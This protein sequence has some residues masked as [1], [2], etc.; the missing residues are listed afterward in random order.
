M[1]ENEETQS[2][3]ESETPTT[4]TPT[5]TE[6]PG[7]EP[8]VETP[9]TETKTEEAAPAPLTAE[10]IKLPEGMTAPEGM[11]TSFAEVMNNADLSAEDRASQLMNLHADAMKQASE[12]ISESWN[13]TREGWVD[14]IKADPE[15]GG[16]KLPDT[17]STIGKV[18]DEFG[19]EELRTLMDESGMGDNPEFVKF[20]YKIGKSF[21]EGTPVSGSAADAPKSLADRLYS[22]GA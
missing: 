2:S 3:T 14:Q 17:L 10:S 8:K 1:N 7:T 6:N 19:S 13:K 22:K 9:A 5:T 20:L 4:E 21:S 12:E 11:L 16:D 15:I 18:V